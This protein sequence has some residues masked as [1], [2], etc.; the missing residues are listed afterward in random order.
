MNIVNRLFERVDLSHVRYKNLVNLLS[1]IF[2]C[3]LTNREDNILLEDFKYI[4]FVVIDCYLRRAKVPDVLQH[5]KGILKC[6]QVVVHL[7][8][9]VLF[10]ENLLEK[11][12]VQSSLPVHEA[13]ACCSSGVHFPVADHIQSLVEC[14]NFI[15]LIR[16]EY[17]SRAQVETVT[18]NCFP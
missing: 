6:H 3:L 16:V 12:M 13:A 5:L 14:H 4:F 10:R 7:V 15:D 8:E 17:C 18:D 11:K 2:F 9:T 1:E